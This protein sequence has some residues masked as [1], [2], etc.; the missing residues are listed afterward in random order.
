MSVRESKSG[1]WETRWNRPE[2]NDP[3]EGQ[4]GQSINMKLETLVGRVISRKNPRIGQATGHKRHALEE[5]GNPKCRKETIYYRWM[6]SGWH[7]AMPST[8]PCAVAR[9][10]LRPERWKVPP[11]PC[12]GD[13]GGVAEVWK[14]CYGSWVF[15][16]EDE[17]RDLLDRETLQHKQRQTGLK[18]TM[19]HA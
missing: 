11:S 13:P 7:T 9:S 8:H 10:W 6:S 18:R 15:K 1:P 4:G 3:H 5:R 19:K 14:A 12:W 2:V 17:Q 16:K